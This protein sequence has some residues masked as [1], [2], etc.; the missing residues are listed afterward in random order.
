MTREVEAGVNLVAC[1]PGPEMNRNLERVY[2]IIPAI[3]AWAR[4][5]QPG[6]LW[7]TDREAGKAMLSYVGPA[8]DP[9]IASSLHFTKEAIAF[10]GTP[11]VV[12]AVFA[13]VREIYSG[14]SCLVN[15]LFPEEYSDAR[16]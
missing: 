15:G 16:P 12:N 1:Q 6:P 10:L 2:A 5:G 13:V 8:I 11:E 7:A 9:L 3:G 4:L 14:H